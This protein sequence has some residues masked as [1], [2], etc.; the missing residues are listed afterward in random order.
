[1]MTR[2]AGLLA[3]LV[4]VLLTATGSPAQ[5]PEERTDPR[6][7]EFIQGVVSGYNGNTLIVNEGWRVMVTDETTFY[8][9]RGHEIPPRVV[10]RKGWIYVE[11]YPVTE[12]MIRADKIYMLPGYVEK[13][14]RRHYPF[15]QMP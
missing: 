14:Q 3:A 7:M 10:P 2:T 5:E 8:N 6:P 11:G 12:N 9:S 1:M 15:I 13:G 4:L